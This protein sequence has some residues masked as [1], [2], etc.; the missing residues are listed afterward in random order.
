MT[1]YPDLRTFIEALD[2][3]GD[4]QHVTESVSADLEAAAITRLSTERETPAPLFENVSGAPSGFRLFGAPASL[5]SVPGKPFAR[6]AL[7]LGLPPETT[8]GELVDHLA[9]A[10]TFTPVPPK[11]VASE[12]APC[13]QNILVGEAATLDRFPIPRVHQDDGGPYPNTWGIIV[14]KTPDGSWTNW[15]IARIMQIDGRHMTG[16]I[17]PSQHIG[18]IWEEWAKLGQPMPFALVQ[19]GDPAIPVVGGMP[20]P[21][22]VDEA[23]YIGALHGEPLKVVPCETVDL[24]VPASAEVVIEGHLSPGRD[25]VEGP[26][27]EFNGYAASE[28]SQQPV[29]TIA[30]ITY[31]D[32]PIWPVVAEGRPVDE[33]HTVI[34]AGQSSALLAELRAAGLPISTVWAPLR[35]AIHW[36]VVTVP[37][38][39]RMVLAKADPAEF[40]RKI[41]DVIDASR[42]GRKFSHIFILDDDIDPADDRDL[43]W[44]LATRVH[45]TDHREVRHGRIHPLM[46]C[47]SEQERH[48]VR[49]PLTIVHALQPAPGHGRMAHSSFYEAYPPDV[50]ARATAQ[51][52]SQ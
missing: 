30:A 52:N 37:P 1:C 22:G 6:I 44:G 17:Q 38:Q 50:Q 18:R 16:Q 40:A 19:G 48:T 4:V 28:T 42:S 14:A 10:R 26:F 43:L 25:A 20:L 11:V 36:A 51:I 49:G 46:Y 41:A 47:Y 27:G 23:G 13:K 39:W 12:E 7:A 24:D 29:Y 32:A 34:G 35:T 21:D 8:A 15:S 5:S 9:R 45:P 33:C 2:T 3:L 31:R